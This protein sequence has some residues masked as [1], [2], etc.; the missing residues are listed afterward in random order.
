MILSNGAIDSLTR[1]A[2]KGDIE[3]NA[4]SKDGETF[5]AGQV[6]CEV[7]GVERKSVDY[8]EFTPNLEIKE[9]VWT[10][11]I[12]GNV[13]MK[14][15][16]VTDDSDSD[17]QM[18]M[19][20]SKRSKQIAK[21]FLK[22]WGQSGKDCKLGSGRRFTLVDYTTAMEPPGPMFDDWTPVIRVER[23]RMEPKSRKQKKM[24]EFLRKN[25]A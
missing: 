15:W 1:G 21:N 2:R 5:Y 8:D 3:V 17:N 25:N 9:V 14:T 10:Q 13:P 23:I 11:K 16:L 24:L 12:V 20:H 19:I 18:V 6:C 7:D 4:L 22:K